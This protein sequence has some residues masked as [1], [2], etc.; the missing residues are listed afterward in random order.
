MRFF[1]PG[2]ITIMI[3]VWHVGVALLLTMIVGMSGRLFMSWRQARA[4]ALPPGYA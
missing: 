3:V 2:D 1:H 4:R